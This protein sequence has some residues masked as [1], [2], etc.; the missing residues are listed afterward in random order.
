VRLLVLSDHGFSDFRYKAH[1]NRWL[2]QHGYLAAQNGAAAGGLENVDWQRSQAYAVGLNSLYINQAGREGQGS[3]AAQ[4]AGELVEKICQELLAWRGPDGKAVVQRALRRDEAF[5][6]P[7]AAY[8]PDLLVGYAPG[9][10]ASSETGLG[11]WKAESVEDNHDH[12][13]ADH[14]IDSQAVPGVLFCNQGLG[15]LSRPS[16]RDIPRLAIGRQI[17]HKD[18]PPAP[19]PGSAGGESKEAI[20]ERLKSLGYL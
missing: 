19:P 12:W 15:E 11:Q 2:N 1:I 3:V 6:G 5:S 10:R 13:G 18:S 4:Q 16:F 14:C 20:E 9:Y 17:T 7:L 8:G